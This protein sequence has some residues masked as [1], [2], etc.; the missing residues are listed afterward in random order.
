MIGW[1]TARRLAD[2]V[3]RKSACKQGNVSTRR[4]SDARTSVV[5]GI[6][7]SRLST[8]LPIEVSMEPT[9]CLSSLGRASLQIQ[10]T[11]GSISDNLLADCSPS[12]GFSRNEVCT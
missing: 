1:S 2:T 8:A 10:G 9:A 3:R 5:L 11:L 12:T 6:A 7:T 4:A